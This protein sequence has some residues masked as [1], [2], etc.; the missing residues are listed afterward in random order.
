MKDPQTQKK[1]KNTNAWKL[2]YQYSNH[3]MEKTCLV[4]EFEDLEDSISFFKKKSHF[5]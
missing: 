2:I 4:N 1:K 5:N 3:E